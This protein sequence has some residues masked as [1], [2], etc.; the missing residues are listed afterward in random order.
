MK[1]KILFIFIFLSS[2]YQ[3]S[4]KPKNYIKSLL[5]SIKIDLW[6]SKL[7]NR[8]KQNQKKN[9]INEAQ[10]NLYNVFKS[11][12]YEEE[13]DEGGF[14]IFIYKKGKSHMIN[15]I[16]TNRVYSD[17][18][19]DYL[20]SIL[21]YNNKVYLYTSKALNQDNIDELKKKINEDFKI[22]IGYEYN[23]LTIENYSYLYEI[24]NINDLKE[25]NQIKQQ[26]QEKAQELK[27][28]ENLKNKNSN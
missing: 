6:L 4:I 27:I 23:S 8:K 9:I 18:K 11:A 15:Y 24:C 16:N 5:K 2:F 26:I 10:K 22:E 1:N 19:I 14:R 12:R 7:F 25:N 28:F 17:F 21:L 13:R 20:D 3:L